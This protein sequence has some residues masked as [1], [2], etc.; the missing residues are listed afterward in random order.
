MSMLIV[1]VNYIFAKIKIVSKR[2][3]ASVV[4]LFSTMYL[5][6]GWINSKIGL[7]SHFV[8]ILICLN[9]LLIIGI[10][11]YIE[12]TI[13]KEIIVLGFFLGGIVFFVNPNINVKDLIITIF[14]IGFSM[15]ILSYITKN[16]IGI[17]DAYLFSL[18]SLFL[19]WEIGVGILLYTL[20][21][22]G[23]IGIVI[24]VKGK[25][26]KKTLIPLGPIALFVTLLMVM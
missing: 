2:N 15:G 20:V 19:G 26:S 9:L 22:S 24:I 21:I 8:S 18:I 11:D 5:Y 6:I 17:G 25:S 23:F 16:G 10:I 13:S 12:N 4:L 3:K 1:S 7:N 14:G